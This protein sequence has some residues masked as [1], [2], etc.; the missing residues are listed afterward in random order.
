MHLEARHREQCMR[1]SA[2]GDIDHHVLYMHMLVR[3]H[4]YTCIHVD[5]DLLA[6]SYS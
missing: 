4:V 6:G 2:D 5:L 1:S 3:T